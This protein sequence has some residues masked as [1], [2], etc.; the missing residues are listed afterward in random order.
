MD[1]RDSI[2]EGGG[3]RVHSE[4]VVHPFIYL[5]GTGGCFADSK[6]AGS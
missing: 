6:A 3:Y 2:P 1:D 5:V 4:F